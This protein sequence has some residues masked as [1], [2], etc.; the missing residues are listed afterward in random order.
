[1]NQSQSRLR[2]SLVSAPAKPKA[3]SFTPKRSS[4]MHKVEKA[5]G[6][7]LNPYAQKPETILI[8]WTCKKPLWIIHPVKVLG[9]FSMEEKEATP[10]GHKASLSK[11]TRQKVPS[12]D[13]PL[14]G[15]EFCKW[16][17]KNLV[18]RYFTSKGL[19]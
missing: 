15:G 3:P 13:C 12:F 16:D 1:M 5:D 6:G 14:C 17:E 18:A 4:P 10:I 9:P 8:C 19:I 2:R 11:L 7:W